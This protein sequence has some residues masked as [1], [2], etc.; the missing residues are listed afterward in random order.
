MA[1]TIAISPQGRLYLE[2][3]PGG[4]SHALPPA[5]APRLERAFADSM[6]AGLLHLATVE[7]Q[8]ALPPEWSFV[9]DFAAAYLTR[10]C[11]SPC[12]EDGKELPTATPPDVNELASWVLRAPPM[13]GLEYLTSAALAAWWSALDDHVRDEM[14]AWKEGPH[15][16]LRQKNPLWRLVGRVTLHLAENKRDPEHPF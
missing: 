9:R 3:I 5:A 13:R 6:A 15:A 7:L 16:Y 10:L 1:L 8:T 4:E 12:T 2:D 14:R 11:H